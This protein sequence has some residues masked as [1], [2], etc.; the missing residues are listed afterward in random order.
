MKDFIENYQ[1]EKFQADKDKVYSA[2]V[3]KS[4]KKFIEQVV[5]LH[6]KMEFGSVN[7]LPAGVVQRANA[8]FSPFVK[9]IEYYSEYE[10]R[11]ATQYAGNSPQL[12]DAVP[13]DLG[14]LD[15]FVTVIDPD[16]LFDFIEDYY[17]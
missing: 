11:L 15:E 12:D 4:P 3:I 17:P 16:E 14:N 10:F 2:I 6:P 1:P 13:L 5:S 7:Y 8:I 9:D